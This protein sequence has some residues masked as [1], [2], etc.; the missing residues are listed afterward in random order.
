MIELDYCD[1]N[2]EDGAR[3]PCMSSQSAKASRQDRGRL[4]RASDGSHEVQ[5]SHRH[6]SGLQMGIYGHEDSRSN[7]PVAGRRVRGRTGAWGEL[8][9]GRSINLRAEYDGSGACQRPDSPECSKTSPRVQSV[10]CVTWFKGL[11]LQ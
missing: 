3:R 5:A 4:P 9:P 11:K 7:P 1:T 6:T 10:T 8:T 2:T